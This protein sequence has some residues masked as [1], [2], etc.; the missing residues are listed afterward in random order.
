MLGIGGRISGE[1]LLLCATLL[2][3]LAVGSFASRFV[4]HRLN[5]PVLRYTVLGFAI[6]S[7]IVVI[8]QA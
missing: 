8:L 7:G 1:T 5:G 3:F 6:I 4:H 2:P